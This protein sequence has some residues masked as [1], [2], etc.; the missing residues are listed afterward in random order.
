MC[1]ER[2]WQPAFFLQ[3]DL[4][5]HSPK[6]PWGMHRIGRPFVLKTIIMPFERLFVPWHSLIR[7][8]YFIQVYIFIPLIHSAPFLR[9]WHILPYTNFF[10]CILP[11]EIFSYPWWRCI[12]FFLT[13]IVLIQ[14]NFP[15]TISTNLLIFTKKA[16]LRFSQTCEL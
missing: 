1:F 12:F 7:P 8:L 4:H 15:W 9:F 16:L 3:L 2:F 6:L 14:W 10:L 5:W 11:R 13:F